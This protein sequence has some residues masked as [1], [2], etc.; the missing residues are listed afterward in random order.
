MRLVNIDITF[1][2]Y[3]SP[4][5]WAIIVY[6]SGC[7]NNCANC[8]NLRLKDDNIGNLIKNEDELKQI[9]DNACKRYK[10]NNIVFSGGDPLYKS[11]I[12]I[13]KQFL[14]KYGLNYNI[15]IYTGFSIEKVKEFGINNFKFIKCGSYNESLK[16]ES[17]NFEDKIQLGSTNQNYFNSFYKQLSINGILTY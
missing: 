9:L 16:Q 3:P 17:G 11:N 7:N 14:E 12:T 8:Q 13:L 6:F 4:N 10:T 5:D 2:D 1:I 15:C